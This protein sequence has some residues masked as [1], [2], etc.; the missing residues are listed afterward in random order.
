MADVLTASDMRMRE[1]LRHEGNPKNL[2]YLAH[3]IYKLAL[4]IYFRVFGFNYSFNYIIKGFNCPKSNT[5]NRLPEIEPHQLF[6]MFIYTLFIH[7][8]FV[9]IYLYV[10]PLNIFS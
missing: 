10:L 1:K 3:K 2:L 9:F 4:E 7:F 6:I 8:I 5:R